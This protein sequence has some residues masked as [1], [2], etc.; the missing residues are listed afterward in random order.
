[1]SI[2][3][4]LLEL[5]DPPY[6]TFMAKLLPSVDEQRI[7]GVRLPELRR[8]TKMLWRERREEAQA[9][10]AEPLPH[11][12][13]DAMNLHA[14]LIGLSTKTP[15]EAFRALERFLPAVDN[16]GTCD[17]L[18]VPAFKHDLDATEAQLHRWMRETGPGT[19]YVVRFAVTQLMTLYMG[20]AFKPDHLAWV[21][22]IERPEYYINMARAWYF[23]YA[24]IQH[25]EETLP[26]FEE[27]DSAG[28]P[29][30]DAWTH[31]K[32]LQK[33]RESRRATPEMRAHLQ[34]LKV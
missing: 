32:A 17:S 5:A 1:M 34:R 10:L 25:P 2:D 26:L 12:T 22:S 4:D 16:W 13:N 31:N 6:R 7:L 27:H 15:Q 20:E 11:A 28:A 9:F 8:Y 21:A 18:R 24:L 29:A 23:S 19:E 30:L 33:A 14:L 3:T